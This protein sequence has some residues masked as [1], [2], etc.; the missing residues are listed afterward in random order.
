M[1]PVV[2]Q[3]EPLADAAGIPPRRPNRPMMLA[4]GGALFGIAAAAIVGVV[5]MM[6]GGGGTSHTP[7]PTTTM[8]SST[9]TPGTIVTPPP[10]PPS[11]PPEPP[12]MPP[13]ATAADVPVPCVE[14]ASDIQVPLSVPQGQH[15]VVLVKATNLGAEAANGFITISSPEAQ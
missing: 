11:M 10:K 3:L 14:N 5:I 13:C 4:L 1:S 12:S 2:A 15:I 6:D 8:P 9:V 7:T